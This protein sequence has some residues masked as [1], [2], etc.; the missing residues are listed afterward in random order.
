MDAD[1]FDAGQLV[2]IFLQQDYPF[3]AFRR[4]AAFVYVENEGHSL[5][6]LSLC[7]MKENHK[8]VTVRSMVLSFLSLSFV[9]MSLFE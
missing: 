3:A 2:L 1:Y 7:F 4:K 5:G 8:E 9:Y 6:T